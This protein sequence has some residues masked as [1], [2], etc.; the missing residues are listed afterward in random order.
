MAEQEYA[1]YLKELRTLLGLASALKADIQTAMN[2]LTEG[3]TQQA[4][5]TLEKAIQRLET[6]LTTP[7]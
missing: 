5:Q 4:Q 3:M 2:L 1:K 6:Y 7:K